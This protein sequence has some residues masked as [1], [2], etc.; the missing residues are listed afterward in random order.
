MI[1]LDSSSDSKRPCRS[2]GLISSL[3]VM[4]SFLCV[5]L[6]AL[7]VMFCSLCVMFK[8]TVGTIFSGSAEATKTLSGVGMLF[9]PGRV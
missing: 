8:S 1:G 4:L 6:L 9:T 3:C 7:C 2:L 5:M